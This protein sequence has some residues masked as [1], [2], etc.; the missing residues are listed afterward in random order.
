MQECVDVIMR[1]FKCVKSLSVGVCESNK[2]NSLRPSALLMGEHGASRCFD[3]NLWNYGHLYVAWWLSVCV[4][5]SCWER[6]LHL[7][8]LFLP[9]IAPLPAN[10]YCGTVLEHTP[11]H[12]Y[13]QGS[14]CICTHTDTQWELSDISWWV[15]YVH[16][17]VFG[18]RTQIEKF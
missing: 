4:F 17:C 1:Y 8:V 10:L 18:N 5:V 11:T 9:L 7:F 16:R 3:S 2:Q 13:L 14:I 12:A 6:W 15:Q